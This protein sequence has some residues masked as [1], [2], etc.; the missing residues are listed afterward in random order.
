[1][2]Q[3]YLENDYVKLVP[4]ELGHVDQYKK[5]ALDKR[6]WEHIATVMETEVDVEQYVK[7]QYAYIEN[8]QRLVFSIFDR[9]S[10]QLI[11]S[12][13]IFDISAVHQHAEIGA[14]WIIPTYWGTAMNTNCKLLLLSYLFDEL[15][16][17][18]VQIKTD[19]LNKRSQRAI[20]ALGASFE[21]QLR[22][23]MKRKDGT[24]RDTMLYSIIQDEWPRIQ[25]Q[26]QQKIAD[27][28]DRS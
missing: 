18:R 1:M 6:I 26:L 25:L 9:L 22:K 17:E 23:H 7:Q 5:I 8:G 10:N 16:F 13:S 19:N 15:K 12:T 11:G 3:I 4:L 27:Y 28:E 24:M 14:T 21:G 2:Q 20:E